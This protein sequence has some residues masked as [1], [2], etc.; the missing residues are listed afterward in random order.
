M[1]VLTKSKFKIGL[2]C[3]NKIVYTFDDRY[4]NRSSED[5]FLASLAEGGFQV[6]ALAR[7][8]YPNGFFLEAQRGDYQS[9]WEETKTLLKQDEVVIYEAS[10][11]MNNLFVMSDI[12]VKKGNTLKLIEVKAKSFDS[13]N[14]NSFIGKN[15]KIYSNWKPYFFDVAFQKHVIQRCMPHLKIESYFILA[16]KSKKSTINGLN[17]LIRLPKKGKERK[18]IKTLISPETA[19]KTS[20]LTKVNISNLIKEILLNEQSYKGSLTFSKA[21]NQFEKTIKNNTFPNWTTNYSSCKNCEFK[22]NPEEEKLGKLSGFKNCF[23]TMHNI[24]EKEFELPNIFEIWN[25]RGQKFLNKGK[26]LLKTVN[27]ADFNT[28]NTSKQLTA[29]D[30]RWIQ[31]KKAVSE[32]KQPFINCKELSKE[33]KKW[34]FPLHFIDFETSAVAIPFT[35]NMKPYEQ[36]AF[37]FSHHQIDENGKITHKSQYLNNKTGDFPNFKFIE[38]LKDAIDHDNGTIFRFASHE[39]SILNTIKEQLEQSDYKDRHKLIQFIRN[40]ATP[41]GNVVQKWNPKRNFV[42]LR[43]IMLRYYYHPL[44][45]GSNSIKAILP[46]ILSTCS[47]LQEKYTQPIISI[48]LSSLNY[49]DSHIW[50]RKE[51]DGFIDPYKQLPSLFSNWTEKQK[52]NIISGLENI[53]DGGVALTAYG[54]LQFNDMEE[55]E[56]EEISNALLKYC[57][58]DTLAMV[59]IY[60]H[61]KYVIN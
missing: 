14:S 12:I 56:R 13:T 46:A 4:A 45:K 48:N 61:L 44:T 55:N 41:T 22:T 17:Q 60:E 26:I 40:I 38:S 36:V 33:M 9:A 50:L 8:H 47:F 1:K 54:K 30:R 2:S 58:L 28:T 49:N 11:L 6:E 59:M 29:I 15:G 20:V 21:L 52:D 31:I 16:D 24:S 34:K 53:S 25:F 10:F 39:N 27:K 5:S 43:Q 51:K 18:N 42:D 37:Q 57:E 35:K 32:D 23:K 19:I 7:M 3:P